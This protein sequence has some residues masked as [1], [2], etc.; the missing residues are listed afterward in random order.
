MIYFDATPNLGTM[1]VIDGQEYELREVRPHTRQ[2]GG[3]TQLLVWEAHCAACGAEFETTTAI[4][5]K[6]INRRCSGCAQAGKPVKGRR[7]RKVV[8]AVNHA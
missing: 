8:V 1:L 5:S 4:K 2:D 3:E 6:S 7:G